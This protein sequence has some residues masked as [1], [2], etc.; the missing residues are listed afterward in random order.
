MANDHITALIQRVNTDPDLQTR[1]AAAT[2][3][4]DVIAIATELGF[5]ISTD[6]I[7]GISGGGVLD[8]SELENIAGGM[9]LDGDDFQRASD[10]V[11]SWR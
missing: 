6:D 2:G 9:G 5:E 4:D 1:F 10:F 3:A 11:S 8:E 7:A